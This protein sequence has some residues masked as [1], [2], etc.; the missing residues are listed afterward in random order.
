MDPTTGPR[1]QIGGGIKPTRPSKPAKPNYNAIHA[2]PLPLKIYPLPPLVPHNPVSL[3]H[4]V[5]LYLSQWLF[6][7]SSHPAEK[8]Q[9]YFSPETRS[10]HVTDEKAIRAL[11][12]SGFFG[13]G[14]LSRSEP[15][16]LDREKRRKGIIVGETSEEIRERRRGERKEFKKERARRE[17]EAI[18]EKL[19]LE[20]GNKAVDK[21]DPVEIGES[22]TLRELSHEEDGVPANG[23]IGHEKTPSS[24]L[25]TER[26]EEITKA[27]LEDSAP[28]STARITSVAAETP[29]NPNAFES[30]ENKEHLQLWPW[31]SFHLRCGLC[32]NPHS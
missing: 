7:P 32:P 3:L 23:H 25:E 1:G 24:P 31:C 5:Y 11:W 18:E 29:S 19:K 12:E 28:G 16:W 2:Q 10:V 8:Y 27:D 9:C 22:K 6:P 20:R 4:I 26:T 15:S 17:L 30:I 21:R 13:K 14:S